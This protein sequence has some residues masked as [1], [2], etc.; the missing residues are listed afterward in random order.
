[1]RREKMT[2][3]LVHTQH[4]NECLM[5]NHNKWYLRRTQHFM[6][7]FSTDQNDI[8]Q[9]E[10]KKRMM[11][12]SSFFYNHLLFDERTRLELFKHK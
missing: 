9:E 10:E 1:M 2:F 7:I 4:V 8:K 5:S 6:S 12:S 11:I 3:R